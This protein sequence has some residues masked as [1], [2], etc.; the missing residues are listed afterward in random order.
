[1]CD[2]KD[3]GAHWLVEVHRLDATFFTMQVGTGSDFSEEKPE[4]SGYP[5]QRVTRGALEPGLR[6]GIEFE[7][8]L[9]QYSL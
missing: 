2:P 1:M 5:A 6:S 7:Q 4:G 8:A 9:F 3:D